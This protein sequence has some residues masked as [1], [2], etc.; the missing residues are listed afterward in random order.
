LDI[1]RVN[2]ILD[3]SQALARHIYVADMLISQT[4]CNAI[5]LVERGVA[6]VKLMSRHR[7]NIAEPRSSGPQVLTLRVP[8]RLIV[9]NYFFKLLTGRN[10]GCPFS[11]HFTSNVV[12]LGSGRGSRESFALSGGCYLQAGHGLSIGEGT[13]WGARVVI[14]SAN[15]DLLKP[16]KAW[17]DVP[18]PVSIGRDCWMGPGAK[19]LPGV[20]LGDRTIV[21]AGA[22]VTRS[23]PEGNI[24]LQ[25]NPARPI[26][27]HMQ[28]RG[29]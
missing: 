7:A 20:S 1:P 2:I 12:L 28:S 15:H 3:F 17:T 16:G 21:A 10:R 19:I 26:D 25:G 18:T 6:P 22:V 27:T 5:E 13:S 4:R 11:V 24:F 14:I 9:L 8:A 23:F 29:G